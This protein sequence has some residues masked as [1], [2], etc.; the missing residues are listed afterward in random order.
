MNAKS[1]DEI[2]GFE[3]DWLASDADGHV[4]IFSTAGGGYAPEEFLQDTEAHDLAIDAI[5]T[6]AA[7]TKA[8]FAPQLPEGLKNTW[9]MMAERGVFAFD[10]DPHGGPYH[11]VAAPEF[12]IRVSALPGPA[13]TVARVL[14]FSHLRFADMAEVPK[15]LLQKR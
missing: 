4:A 11:L 14:V 3:F 6:S 7:S 2:L 9:R 12:A 5:L 1:A 10:S 8:Q 13:A 15:A